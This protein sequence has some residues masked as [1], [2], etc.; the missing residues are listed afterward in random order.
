M[1]IGIESHARL[2]NE[3]GYFKN[4]AHTAGEDL[5]TVTQVY[6]TLRRALH[7]VLGVAFDER[8]SDAELMAI[9]GT[10]LEQAHAG[11]PGRLHRPDGVEDV[12]IHSLRQSV[13]NLPDVQPVEPRSHVI[14]VGEPFEGLSPWLAPPP[15]AGPRC[16]ESIGDRVCDAEV[17]DGHCPEHGEVGPPT[18]SM[19]PVEEPPAVPN[20]YG[21]G[22]VFHRG[23]A[24]PEHDQLDLVANRSGDVMRVFS[25]DDGEGAS[26]MRQDGSS[27]SWADQL[28]MNGTLWEIVYLG[29]GD[30][31]AAGQDSGQVSGE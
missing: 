8:R 15:P 19:P 23:D 4:K 2:V 6:D 5:E 14:P 16:G 3:W 9:L 17:V 21:I 25:D 22:R 28:H 31:Q 10:Q 26:V 30:E 29:E 24:C 13:Y 12:T 18:E 20:G 11:V 7:Q 27:V 1:E